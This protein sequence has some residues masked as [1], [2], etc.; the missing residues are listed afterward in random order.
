M[1]LGVTRR[2]SLER[3]N[4][5]SA[6]L[7]TFSVLW[8]LLAATANAQA[9]V[10][11]DVL[12]INEV[13]LA[14][15]A[16]ALVTEE[17]MSRLAADPRY[18][19]EFYVESLDSPLFSDQT[20]QQDI[21]A[22]LLQK[23]RNR[24]IDVIVATGPAPISFLLRNS[25]TFLPDVPVVFCGSTQV[26]A[27]NLELTSRFTGTWMT[28]DAASTLETAMRL[29]PGIR[30]VVVVSGSS[31]FDKATLRLAKAS[32][33]AHPVPLEF[34]Y[35][36]DLDMDSLLARLRHL[37]E[38]TVVL[39]LT[40]FRDARGSQ[41]MNATAAL[42][43]V[44]RAAN[45]P[46][47]GVSDVYVGRG[48]VGGYVVSFAEQG[49]IAAALVSEIFAGRN[50]ANIPIVSAPSL[51]MF[52]ARQLERWN[53]SES[54]LPAGSIVLN[55]EVTL[56]ERAKWI[57]LAAFSVILGLVALAAY[58]LY[59]QKQLIAARNEQTRLSGMLINAHEDER[60]RLASE[61][62]DDFS[63]RLALLSLGLET[64]AEI[65]PASPEEAN[66]QL[67]ELMNSASELGADL[68]TLS[69]RLHS[70]TLERLG[71][72]PGVAAFCKEFTAQH[73]M[74]VVF[75]HQDVPRSVSPD[76]ALC[77][78]RVVQEALRNVKKHSEAARAEVQ[79][80]ALDRTLHLSIA[81]DG[82]GFDIQPLSDGRGLGLW[83]MQE[84]VRLL[85]GQFEIHSETHRGTRIDVRVSLK[86]TPDTS[87]GERAGGPMGASAVVQDTAPVDPTRVWWPSATSGQKLRRL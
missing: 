68:H 71:L 6:N 34:T 67:Q 42:P 33:D 75:S 56:W 22:E 47:F 41:F 77:L 72:A 19:T 9:P 80:E 83:S 43:L 21:E 18:Q 17:V 51:Y 30:N 38:R 31:Q 39:Y 86:D 15:P 65:I 54:R 36:T 82:K 78:F 25:E 52:D 4:R 59:E 26:Q 70:S 32:L 46:V 24:K 69:H 50:P 13:G 1:S 58:L 37:P 84:R 5:A 44:S 40:F 28:F 23:Y 57:L 55:R 73:G 10:R 16:I 66:R 7:L 8:V 79:L 74:Q 49:K 87:G 3:A 35:L 64:A 63:Q 14:H 20:P 45:A 60:S 62:H 27:G 85:G 61:L 29:S 12:I 81:D 76:I 48:I 11:K 2:G 53:F